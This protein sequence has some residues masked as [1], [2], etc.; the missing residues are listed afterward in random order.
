[1]TTQD[2][3]Y[4]CG[5]I[6]NIIIYVRFKKGYLCTLKIIV[7]SSILKLLKIKFNDFIFYYAKM[8]EFII[9]SIISVLKIILVFLY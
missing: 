6:N 8:I 2:R 9:N 5:F 1:M 7:S 4:I 3:I